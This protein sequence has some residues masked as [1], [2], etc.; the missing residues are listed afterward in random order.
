MPHLRAETSEDAIPYILHTV[1]YTSPKVLIRRIYLTIIL[2]GDHF[3][4]SSHPTVGFRGNMLGEI[5]C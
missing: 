3:L 5:R 2:V 1:L 4:C